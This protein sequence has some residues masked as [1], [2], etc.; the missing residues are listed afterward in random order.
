MEGGRLPGRDTLGERH[1][2]EPLFL[3]PSP[4]CILL[5][6]ALR[7]DLALWE[8]LRRELPVPGVRV[9]R[10]AGGEVVGAPQREKT[11]VLMCLSTSGFYI[12][13]GPPDYCLH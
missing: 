2:I 1:E 9:Y 7:Q 6:S 10:R 12:L 8:I 13:S 4:R 3:S 11:P 5:A